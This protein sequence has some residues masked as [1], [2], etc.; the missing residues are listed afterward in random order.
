ML[1]TQFWFRWT[2]KQ[3]VSCASGLHLAHH[4]WLQKCSTARCKLLKA[5]K[6][7]LIESA[8]DAV[9]CAYLVGLQVVIEAVE[10][11]ESVEFFTIP[12]VQT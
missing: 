7:W 11:A 4:L 8:Y 5:N 3:I 6:I 12:P 1:R 2:D 10:Y 9:G